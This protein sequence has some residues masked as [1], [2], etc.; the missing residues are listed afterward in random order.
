MISVTGEQFETLVERAVAGI[1]E[2]FASHLN[3]V[4]FMVA[5]TP[6]RE[7]LHKSG[8]LHGRAT[9]LGLY[10]GIPL[11][12][13]NNGYNG[14]MPDVITIFQRPH[15]WL[16]RDEAGLATAVHQTVWHEVAHY[17]GLGHGAIRELESGSNP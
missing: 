7:Q 12:A 14:V 1:P 3:N 9:L 8:I 16:A 11:P 13:R 17:F 4:A 15:E 5:D 10:E 2:R 6:S